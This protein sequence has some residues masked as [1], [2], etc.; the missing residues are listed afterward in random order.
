[1]RTLLSKKRKK[2]KQVRKIRGSFEPFGRRMVLPL[3]A[4]SPGNAFMRLRE[5]HTNNRI[6]MLKSIKFT[7]LVVSLRPQM[8]FPGR[9]HVEV[10]TFAVQNARK[11]SRIISNTA[12]FSPSIFQQTS[13]SILP[14]RGFSF[15]EPSS[16]E[17]P[18]T[19]LGH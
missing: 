9:H 17:P 15:P 12:C 1:M 7:C 5:N 4:G 10:E 19:P 18:L 11:R 14:G 13:P 3:P 6:F 2:S 16:T 8:R